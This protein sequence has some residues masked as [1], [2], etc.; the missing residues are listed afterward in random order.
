VKL[1]LGFCRNSHGDATLGYLGI[2]L[3]F[4]SKSM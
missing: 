4:G 2:D 3:V 1:D